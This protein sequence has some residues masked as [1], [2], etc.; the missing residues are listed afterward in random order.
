MGERTV[1]G[2]SK[3]EN[4]WTN[5]WKCEAKTYKVLGANDGVIIIMLQILAGYFYDSLTGPQIPKTITGHDNEFILWL[6]CSHADCWLCTAQTI[7]MGSKLGDHR[8]S[9]VPKC[10][11][12]VMHQD[13][14]LHKTL[15]TRFLVKLCL[16][17]QLRN[18][19]N[20][21]KLVPPNTPAMQSV[22]TETLL[23][24]LKIL[25]LS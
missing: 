13:R 21:T 24:F 10:V 20:L 17:I 8:S 14:S 11:E 19:L 18:L 3:I 4:Y 23:G 12:D 7:W 15:Q 22:W 9:L 6:Q 2:T 5:K 16:V 1:F 25:K